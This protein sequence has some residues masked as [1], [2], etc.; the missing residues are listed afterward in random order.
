V[1]ELS[2][3]GSIVRLVEQAAERE[4]FTRVA[5][6]RLEVGQLSGV[7]PQALRFAL[8]AITAGTCLEGVSLE[9]L[10]PPGLGWCEPCMAEV[11][12]GSRADPCP[13]CGGYPVRPTSGDALRVLDVLVADNI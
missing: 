10:E 13:Q 3:A 11:P 5:T 4:K 1:H 2:L 6:L 7:E 8:T 9:L 12:L